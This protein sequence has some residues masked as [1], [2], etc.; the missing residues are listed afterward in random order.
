MKRVAAPGQLDCLLNFAAYRARLCAEEMKRRVAQSR[1]VTLVVAIAA[2]VFLMLS[3]SAHLT[4]S[5]YPAVCVCMC[6]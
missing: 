5:P 2:L 3:S 6:A 1:R 4:L